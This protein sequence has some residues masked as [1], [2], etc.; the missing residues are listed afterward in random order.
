MSE[1]EP[2][3]SAAAPSWRAALVRA[4]SGTQPSHAR[5]T[6]LVPGLTPERSR[7][8]EFAYP[9][10]PRPAAVL[11]G[12][13]DRPAAPS[14]LLTTRA[15]QLRNHAGQISFPGGS[16]EPGESPLAGALREAREEIGLAPGLVSL[17][18]YLPDHILLTGFR[19]TPVIA[20][21]R[22]DF[23]IRADAAE[24]HDVFEVPLERVLTSA[25]YATSVRRVGPD[26]IRTLAREIELE[27]H[28][29]DF[30]G[31]NIWGA[32]A[33]ILLNLARRCAAGPI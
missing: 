27:S 13:V 28:A 21:V 11:I 8:L 20:F 7:E 10:A 26:R 22:P 29:V 19:V 15:T 4:L 5:D 31:R 3:E 24:V 1:P 25:N 17:L 30:E 23:E 14:V 32:T 33:G 12:I 2:Q 18:G 6:W 16:L 9:P